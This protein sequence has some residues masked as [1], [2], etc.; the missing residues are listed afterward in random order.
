M[1]QD[2]GYDVGLYYGAH[3]T[4]EKLELQKTKENAKLILGIRMMAGKSL[5]IPECSILIMGS[6]YIPQGD[7]TANLDQMCG[8][9]IRKNHAHAPIIVDLRDTFSFF[10]KHATL[11]EEYYMSKKMP[12]K[13]CKVE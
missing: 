2:A 13:H 4:E 1:A 12:M 10:K 8:R 3:N 11:R 7:N 6:S 9:I 5:N